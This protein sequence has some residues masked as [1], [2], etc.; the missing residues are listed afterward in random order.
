[1][2]KKFS[3]KLDDFFGIKKSGS[4]IKIE[5]FAGLATFLAMAYILT[6]NPNNILF[7]GQSDPRWSSVFIATALGAGIG[8]LL[9]A[10]FAKMPLAQAPGMGLNATIGGVI[11][12]T[13]G[14][15][16]SFGNA[17]MIV[18]I[19]GLIFLMLSLM[20]AG[21][22]KMGRKISV[23]EKIFDGMPKEIRNAIP[24]GIGLFIALIGMK[25]AN[26]VVSNKWTLLQLVDLT[27]KANWVSNG[28]ARNALVA[29]FGL[30][31]IS[32][33]SHYKV[34][35]SV[36]L[37]ILSATLLALPLGVTNIDIL[38]GKTDGITWSFLDSFKN[39]FSMNPEKGGIFLSCF[40]EGFIF[41]KGSL[42]TTVML[43]MT[44][45]MIDMFDTMGTIV[46]CC[47]N[48]KL[49]DKE[50]KPKNY[51]KI[52]NSDSIA[53]VSGALLGTST[54]TTFVESST[55]VV[56]GGRT[57]VTAIVTAGLFL[58]SLFLS[59]LFLSIPSAATAPA[60]ILV[61]FF[62]MSPVKDIDF[63]D[64]TE[65][66]PAFLCILMMVCA[67]SIS[68][69]IMFGILSYVIIKACSGK[70]KQITVPTYIV[71]L[72]FVVKIIINVI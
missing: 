15:S 6:V 35:G 48:A 18:L 19:S 68:D 2:K 61:G 67:Y 13:L 30:M 50:G 32:I 21:K 49:V 22:D 11:G 62:M 10:L 26:I 12:G 45:L 57:G 20:P 63:S 53:T 25:N 44:F 70:A 46:G 47:C 39:F 9:M 56:E 37:G 1:M 42:M 58:L 41:P 65:G 24:V 31:V 60:L 3:K 55:G 54:V 43:V 38:L 16:Y 52:M 14:F 36:I 7:G 59:P 29:L 8:T 72:L 33:L 34:K 27:D 64:P 51:D 69:G 17:M 4:E 66:I 23:R 71:A 5:I 40:T 28:I